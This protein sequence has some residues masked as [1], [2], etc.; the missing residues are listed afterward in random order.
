MA[1]RGREETNFEARR[2]PAALTATLGLLLLGVPAEGAPLKA[3][4]AVAAQQRQLHAVVARPC[5]KGETD[6][7]VVC[8]SSEEDPNRIPRALRNERVAGER[9]R[10]L[11][12]EPPSAAAALAATKGGCRER[13]GFNVDFIRV[14]IVLFKIG[15]HLLDPDSDPPPPPLPSNPYSSGE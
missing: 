13:C 5:P 11:P 15:R 10:L 12:G 1:G 7:I 6:E 9:V 8:G 2:R 4:E 3:E 14:G